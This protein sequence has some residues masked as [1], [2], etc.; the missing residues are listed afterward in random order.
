[1]N[2]HFTPRKLQNYS[3]TFSKCVTLLT[4]EI[5]ENHLNVELDFLPH[6][7]KCSVR[8]VCATLFGMNENDEKIDEI[9]ATT[10][11]IFE[12]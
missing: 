7:E 2:H 1:M 12:E 11:V 8:G 5:V 3:K 9:S 6:L 10:S 4:H